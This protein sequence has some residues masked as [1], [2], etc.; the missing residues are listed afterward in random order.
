[1]TP[2]PD[3]ALVMRN[4][5]VGGRA[6]GLATSLGTCSGL[7]VHATAAALGLSAVLVASSRAFTAVKLLGA[8]YLLVLGVRTILQAG[9]EPRSDPTGE[10][11]TSAWIGY[12]QG[13]LTNV[14]N[15]KV[16]VFFLSLL[17]QFV[18]AGDGFVGRVLV[19][20][21]VFIA[22]GLA[23]LTAYTFALDALGATLSRARVRRAIE[24]VT[25]GV[26]VALGVRLALARR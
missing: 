5:L 6:A 15:P 14:L 22:I 18:E 25:G 13:V 3:M 21:A 16:A 23:W 8:A 12:R 1:M 11:A 20:A 10:R 19:L 4:T 17:P 9:R 26:L 2:G 7:L 24:T